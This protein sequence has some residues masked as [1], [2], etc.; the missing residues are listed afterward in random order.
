MNIPQPAAFRRMVDDW[1]RLLADSAPST[2]AATPAVEDLVISVFR[3]VSHWI[4]VRRLDERLKAWLHPDLRDIRRALDLIANAPTKPTSD[5]ERNRS[6]ALETA[7][8]QLSRLER[9]LANPSDSGLSMIFEPTNR[10]L[11]QALRHTSPQ[12]DPSSLVS[13]TRERLAGLRPPHLKRVWGLIRH[14]CRL[15]P[16]QPD[17]REDG[18]F[19]VS[20]SRVTDRNFCR[21]G[22]IG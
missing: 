11:E 18:G 3:A 12:W 7:H 2:E 20:A 8:E 6:L 1:I 15:T 21:H 22:Y 9:V 17:E 13:L 10:A 4:D 5:A 19:L 14:E 16:L